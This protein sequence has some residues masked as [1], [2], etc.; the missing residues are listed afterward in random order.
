MESLVWRKRLYLLLGMQC[1]AFGV[2]LL[3]AVGL[4]ASP[5]G[6]LMANLALVIP[7][8]IGLLSVGY[9][10][11]AL[12]LTKW[13]SKARFAY[14]SLLY[15]LFFALFFQL[16]VWLLQGVTFNAW[17]AQVLLGISAIV[18]LDVGKFLLYHGQGP[19]LSTV[20][21]IYALSNRTK[22]SLNLMSKLVTLTI[23]SIAMG[24]SL[25]HG[26]WFYQLGYLSLLYLLVAGFTLKWLQKNIQLP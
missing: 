19:K 1:D 12:S 23:I 25:I 16:Y 10:I 21:L 14:L 18:L 6:M 4:G 22:S 5:F 13:L 17:P 2:S 7:L 3:L 11:T 26:D 8:S 24:L 15:S 20:L 9:D